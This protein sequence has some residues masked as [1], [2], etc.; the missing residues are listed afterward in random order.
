MKRDATD[1][2]N[3]PVQESLPRSL[4]STFQALA[5]SRGVIFCDPVRG[6]SS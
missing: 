1:S 6:C 4:H 5:M 2:A 3:E